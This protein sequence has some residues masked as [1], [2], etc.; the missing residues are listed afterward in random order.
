M[1][2]AMEAEALE[3]DCDR[4]EAALR[5]ML[6]AQR[7]GRLRVDEIVM[8]G[9]LLHVV[10][11]DVVQRQDVIAEVALRAGAG[12]RSTELIAPSLEDVF[13]ARVRAGSGAGASAAP[14]RAP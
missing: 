3:V 12:L 2:D 14:E 8:H 7:D 11:R 5:A 9:A 13:I 10:G 1:K 4:P 6:E